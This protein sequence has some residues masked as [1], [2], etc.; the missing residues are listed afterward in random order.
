[1]KAVRIH[2]F[3]ASDVLRLEDVPTP[4]PADDEVLV[5]IRAASVNPIDYKIREGKIMGKDALP[6][7]LGRDFSGVIESLGARASGFSKGDAVFALLGHDRG[8]YAEYVAAKASL[9][10]AK[11]KNLDHGEAAAVPLA[12]ITAWQGMVEHGGV[13]AGQRVL[14][15]GGA[16]GVG[17][18]AIQ[19]AKAKGCWV[20][21]TVS[22]SDKDFVLGLG[23]D[24]AID[25][26]NER[27]EDQVSNLDLVYDLIGGETQA[28]SFAVLKPGGALISTLQE[29]D[30]QKAKEKN[31]RTA[32]YMAEAN[33]S[34][35]AEIAR[36]I[37]DGKIKP[38]VTARFPL[39]RAAK[40]QDM[41][42]KEHPRGKIVLM[43]G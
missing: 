35:L 37:E 5:R 33:G 42:E 14:I 16:G 38:Q 32:H 22:G 27:F 15:Q 28:R 25:Y 34:Q 13:R 17:H 23:A 6:M 40:A 30:K 26:K 21:T 29:P 2:A 10:A 43:V 7:I 4:K 1:M 11:P 36:L 3:G 39:D 41:L 12:A 8:A 20:A 19:I 31:L 9:L 18:M 24:K